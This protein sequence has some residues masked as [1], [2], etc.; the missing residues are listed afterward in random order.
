VK[1]VGVCLFFWAF[2][3]G[4][5]SAPIPQMINYQGAMVDT[6]G[7][8]V[9]STLSITF[10]IWN[11]PTSPVPIYRL[12]F[13]TQPAVQVVD[14]LFDVLLGSVTP[15][16]RSVFSSDTVWLQVQVSGNP[17]MTPRQRIAS[18]AYAYHA[19]YAD[20]AGV[21]LTG[22]GVSYARVYTVAE[23][24]GDFT[25]VATAIAAIL[26]GPPW[27]IR[28][29]AG[30]YNEPNFTIPSNVTL[31]GAGR[32]CCFLIVQGGIAMPNPSAMI[33]DFDIQTSNSAIGGILIT[34]SEITVS[35]NNITNIMGDGITIQGS[36]LKNIIHDNKIHDCQ[37]WGIVVQEGNQPF[38]HDNYIDMNASG[39]VHFDEAGGSLSN[40]AIFDN[41]QYGVYI[42]GM[43]TWDIYLTIDDNQIGYNS[44][45]IMVMWEYFEP[46]IM[47]ND[48]FHNYQYGIEVVAGHAHIV[49]N[50]IAYS[51]SAGIAV[52][53][54]MA[55]ANILGNKIWNNQT[56][57]IECSGG[58]AGFNSVISS[59]I[60]IMNGQDIWYPGPAAPPFTFNNNTFDTSPGF[61]PGR[62]NA[63]SA[64]LPILP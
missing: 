51:Y 40:N 4:A 17:A 32:D 29:M 49:A 43:T 5:W 59:N 62:Y 23:A 2:S 14:G 60:I 24:G 46:R 10:S 12:W 63:T 56:Y 7:I 35:D 36:G 48:I 39:G 61:A 44:T 11:H 21:A 30:T 31:R 13:E 15:I 22:P 28:V 54:G 53:G 18:V 57:G 37:G 55:W 41:G 20:T 45:G 47:G 25:S 27:L 50:T 16:P 3:M 8:P 38:I 42:S 33:T 64:G 34:A 1:V 9:D 19:W 26:P 6:N 52:S 58:A